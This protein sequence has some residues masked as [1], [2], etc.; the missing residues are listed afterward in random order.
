M[1][2][3]LWVSSLGLELQTCEPPEEFPDVH[4]LASPTWSL[5]SIG[6][7]G[8]HG[9]GLDCPLSTRMTGGA[10]VSYFVSKPLVKIFERRGEGNYLYDFLVSIQAS[11]L[12]PSLV[13]L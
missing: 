4:V 5:P 8:S 12:P 9:T 13:V 3:C 10:L 6:Q 2:A 11:P 7:G 1:P